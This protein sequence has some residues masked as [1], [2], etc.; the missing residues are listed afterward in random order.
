[1]HSNLEILH[2]LEQKNILPN[3]KGAN[4]AAHIKSFSMLLWLEDRNIFPDTHAV[5][6]AACIR[7]HRY[8]RLS[9]TKRNLS[10]H[11]MQILPNKIIVKMH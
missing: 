9:R 10:N 2:W 4:C 8:A 11:I 7:T 3:T 6:S 1:M 5:N